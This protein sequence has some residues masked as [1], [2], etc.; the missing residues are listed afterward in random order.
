MF[1]PRRTFSPTVVRSNPNFWKWYK[2]K[3]LGLEERITSSDFQVKMYATKAP[4][5]KKNQ[6]NSQGRQ[7]PNST[8]D[9]PK[10]KAFRC[11]THKPREYDIAC[12][13]EKKTHAHTVNKPSMH[14]KKHSLGQPPR[15]L[16]QS[17]I[18]S[19]DITT[20]SN[21]KLYNFI[22]FLYHHTSI[23]HYHVPS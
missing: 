19:S 23:I 2:D 10:T 6:P 12:L 1:F 9:Y 17:H 11:S 5:G 21:Y 3:P 20:Y 13:F 16:S 14:A 22:I 7:L 8:R 18:L 15:I 4:G